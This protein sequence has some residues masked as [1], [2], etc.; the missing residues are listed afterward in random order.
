MVTRS[1]WLQ[2]ADERPMYG[3]LFDGDYKHIHGRYI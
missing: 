2:L 1:S 3:T